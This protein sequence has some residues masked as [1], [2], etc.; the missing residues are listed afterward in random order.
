MFVM[1]GLLFYFAP[2][3]A[4]QKIITGTILSDTDSKP[5]QGVTVQNRQTA[6][7][8][9]T[10]SAGFYSIAATPGQQLVFTFVGYGNRTIVVGNALMIS[11][12]LKTENKDLEN[13]VV[14]ALGINR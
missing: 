11:L 6:Q 8:T 5:L 13:V 12:E 2:L 7:K 14:T 10:N 4:Q 1:C 9:Q 3:F